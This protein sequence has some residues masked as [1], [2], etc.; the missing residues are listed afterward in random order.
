MCTRRRAF[1]LIELLVVIAI[2]AILIALLLPAVQQAREAARRT[3][4]KNNLKQMGLA[5]HNY[6]DTYGQFPMGVMNPGGQSNCSTTTWAQQPRNHIIYSYLLPYVDQAPLYNLINFSI[7]AGPAWYN[8]GTC[9]QPSDTQ[10]PTIA[11]KLA[12]FRCPSDMPLGEPVTYSYPSSADK[13]YDITG[14]YRSS[15]GFVTTSNIWHQ[16][17]N[18]WEKDTSAAKA[19]VGINGAANIGYISDGTSNTMV[20]MEQQ[21]KKAYPF[22]PFIHAWTLYGETEVSVAKPMFWIVTQPDTIRQTSGSSKHTGGA[23]CLLTDGAVRFLSQNMSI[24]TYAA[25]GTIAGAE[26]LGEF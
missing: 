3:Q 24:N 12:V 16:M 14:G 18:T 1:T 6:H 19:V 4:C 26:T 21:Y 25:L 2:I 11:K 13:Y 5:M 15:Y 10:Y 7:P 22:G 9:A 17:P 23:H 8:N 20:F